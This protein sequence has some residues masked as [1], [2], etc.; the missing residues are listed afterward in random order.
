MTRKEYSAGMVKHSFWYAEFKKI[1]MLLSDGKS[2]EEIKHMSWDNNIFAAPT[3]E[4]AAQIY[5]T[6]SNR[7]RSLPRDFFAVF[8]RFVW[9]LYITFLL[10]L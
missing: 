2:M 10:F 9:F 3:K 6:V 5:N 7:V 8:A 4:R 1:L